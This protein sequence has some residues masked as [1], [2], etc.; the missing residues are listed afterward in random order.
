MCYAVLKVKY[1]GESEPVTV[2]IEDSVMYD[3]KVKELDDNAEVD[4]YTVFSRDHKIIRKTVL[5]RVP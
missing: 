2:D 5:E 3:S 4:S 1:R